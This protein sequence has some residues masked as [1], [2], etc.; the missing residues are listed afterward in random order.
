[1][2]DPQNAPGQPNDP[3]LLP[4][5]ESQARDLLLRVGA[6]V[7]RARELK[8]L[9][10]RAVSEKSGVSPRYLAQLE[11]G[12]GN[13]SIGLL[14]RV[15][16]ALDH[17]IEWL[18]GPDDPWTSDALRVADLFRNAPEDRRQAALS[19]LS[20]QPSGSA[21]ANRVCL[22]GLR[23]AGKSTLG[24]QVGEK[25]G[26]PFCELNV[27]IETHAGMAVGEVMALYGQE[28]YRELERQALNRVIATRD[29]MILAVAG[30]I[31]SEPDTFKTLLTH[32]H[33]IWVKASP[34]EHMTRVQRQGDTRPMAGNPE[35]MEQLKKILSSRQDLYQRATEQLDTSGKPLQ[36]SVDEL[37]ALLRDGGYLGASAI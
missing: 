2:T 13:I 7:R 9:P 31:V 33:T 3:S 30:G 4:S 22:I 26:V 19:L 34:Q 18:V 11:S 12:E 32:F 17:R 10:R 14:Q 24:T 16:T 23:G 8:G 35:A 37:A 21:R 6:R 29:R 1:M 36:V 5:A 15:A 20:A 25:L 28:G 27:E